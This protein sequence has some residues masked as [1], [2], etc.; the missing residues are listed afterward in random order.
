VIVV[1]TLTVMGASVV[2]LV[3]LVELAVDVETWRWSS[4]A[5]FDV[6]ESEVGVDGVVAD[7]TLVAAGMG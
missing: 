4:A 7:V 6:V 5:G 3:M 1:K 2:A